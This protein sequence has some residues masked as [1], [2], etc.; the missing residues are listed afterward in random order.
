MKGYSSWIHMNQQLDKL[1][2]CIIILAETYN[3]LVLSVT[4]ALI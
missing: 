2:Y 4:E 3:S 1:F